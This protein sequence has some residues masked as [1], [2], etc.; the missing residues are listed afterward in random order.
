MNTSEEGVLWVTFLQTSAGFTSVIDAVP[1]RWRQERT[2]LPD[3]KRSVVLIDHKGPAP[4]FGFKS[5]PENVMAFEPGHSRRDQCNTSSGLDIDMITESEPDNGVKSSSSKSLLRN[6]SASHGIWSAPSI[7]SAP[8][9]TFDDRLCVVCMERPADLQLLPCRHDRFC[10]R[11][12]VETVG[13]QTRPTA[14]P[15]CPLCRAAIHA[16]VLVSPS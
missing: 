2:R 11:C 1:I 12:I 9:S 5:V 15:P 16:L 4:S 8:L 7:P 6:S 13:A 3:S 14:A 10:R